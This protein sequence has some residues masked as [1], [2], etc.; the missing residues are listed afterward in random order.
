MT[1]SRSD[2]SGFENLKGLDTDS[3]AIALRQAYPYQSNLSPPNRL[4]FVSQNAQC[5]ECLLNQQSFHHLP[6][7]AQFR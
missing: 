7:G 6:I 5:H 3:A 2:L 1:G 4:E